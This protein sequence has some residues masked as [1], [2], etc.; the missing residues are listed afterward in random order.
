MLLVPRIPWVRGFQGLAVV[1]WQ[2]ALERARE[3]QDLARKQR[4]IGGEAGSEG[5]LVKIENCHRHRRPPH[6]QQQ[7]REDE[8]ATTLYPKC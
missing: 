7:Q 6:Q 2:E 8:A 4:Q 5:I 3:S 1:K